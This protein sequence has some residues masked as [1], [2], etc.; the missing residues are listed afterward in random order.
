MSIVKFQLHLNTYSFYQS[1]EYKTADIAENIQ[2]CVLYLLYKIIN[3][4][5]IEGASAMSELRNLHMYVNISDI[6]EDR[7]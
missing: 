5:L 3:N 4:K 1:L 2:C 6:C 7:L